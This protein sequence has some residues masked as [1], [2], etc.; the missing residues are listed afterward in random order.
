MRY[1]KKDWKVTDLG[2]SVSIQCTN[3]VKA[4]VIDQPA[5]YVGEELIANEITYE[6]DVTEWPSLN[7]FKKNYK[8]GKKIDTKSQIYPVDDGCN[9]IEILVKKI[10][11]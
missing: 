2:D 6:N 7:W 10:K 3:P 11:K 8:A 9:K 1:S 5:I 4:T